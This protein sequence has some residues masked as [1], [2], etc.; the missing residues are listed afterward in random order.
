MRARKAA[1][2]E[3][4]G[5]EPGER[6]GAV[7]LAMG[8]SAV[9]AGSSVDRGQRHWAQCRGDG[10]ARGAR[11]IMALWEPL[12]LAAAAHA[13]PMPSP[14]AYAH[15]RHPFFWLVGGALS[16]GGHR[17]RRAWSLK[18]PPT[19]EGVALVHKRASGFDGGNGH[20][21]QFQPKG[22]GPLW[23]GAEDPNIRWGGPPLAA[24]R[25]QSYRDMYGISCIFL[26]DRRS[27]VGP[28]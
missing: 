17:P 1:A 24:A 27:A 25:A 28:Y 19:V 16:A 5:R 11:S 4:G 21:T 9:A 26:V 15:A 23:D 20:T 22:H 18:P 13:S 7:S 6:T 14:R 12:N 8:Q 3:E 10:S 2:R